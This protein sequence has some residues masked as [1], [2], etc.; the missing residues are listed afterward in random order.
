MQLVDLDDQ[1]APEQ[2]EDRVAELDATVIRSMARRREASIEAGRALNELKKLLGHGKWQRHFEETFAPT[3][4][5]LRTA[6]RWM[7]RARKADAD[8]QKRHRC[9]SGRSGEIANCEDGNVG[10]ALNIG[11]DHAIEKVV[12]CV[13]GRNVCNGDRFSVW[14][15][16]G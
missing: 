3:G 13:R 2:I 9:R 7:K 6:E 4:I 12:L 14:S 10:L 1:V 5:T 15:G 16:K 8:S 11:G